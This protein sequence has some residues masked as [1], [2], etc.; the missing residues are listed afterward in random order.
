[1]TGLS[2]MAPSSTALRPAAVLGDEFAA[3]GV[4]DEFAAGGVS[5]ASSG[6]SRGGPLG[7]S[8]T[9]FFTCDDRRGDRGGGSHDG[10]NGG[11]SNGGG[12]PPRRVPR[13][14]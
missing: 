7:L 8:P 6:L 2:V 5:K 9:A 4:S 11:G 10:S 14:T 3:G 12:G 1:M 13:T